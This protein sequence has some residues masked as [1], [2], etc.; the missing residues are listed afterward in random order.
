MITLEHNYNN[1][2]GPPFPDDA[3]Y[4]EE[5]RPSRPRF[6]GMLPPKQGRDVPWGQATGTGTA[7]GKNGRIA[8][9]NPDQI[10]VSGGR[11]YDGDKPEWQKTT[12]NPDPIGVSGGREYNGDKAPPSELP[13]AKI[14]NCQECGDLGESDGDQE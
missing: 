2:D 14:G 6:R 10:Y 4:P 3:H 12:E 9:E 11:E 1:N 8:T 7:G 13:C 5:A